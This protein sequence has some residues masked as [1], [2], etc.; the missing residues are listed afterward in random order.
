[1]LPLEVRPLST[2]RKAL[3]A[4]VDD[5]IAATILVAVLAWLT[6]EGVLA[7]AVAT[8]IGVVGIVILALI[9]Y[10]TATA[11]AMHPKVGAWMEGRRGIALT[12]IKPDGMVLID[13]EL[14]RATSR[15]PIEKGAAVVVVKTEG[16]RAVVEAEKGWNSP[17]QGHYSATPAMSEN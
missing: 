11:L 12:E 13:G 8:A 6:M 15:D 14:W 16:L 7:P 17:H 10:K 2:L 3:L 1:M 5:V 9:A 4:V